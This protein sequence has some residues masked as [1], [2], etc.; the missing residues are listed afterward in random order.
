MNVSGP[1]RIAT[2][3]RLPPLYITTTLS[4]SSVVALKYI[5]IINDR[6]GLTAWLEPELSILSYAVEIMRQYLASS[7]TTRRA[8]DRRAPRAVGRGSTKSP[9]DL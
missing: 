3:S 5:H 9:R 6:D 4:E 7:T 2:L 1:L 8:E